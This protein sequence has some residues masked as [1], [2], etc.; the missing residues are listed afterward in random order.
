MSELWTCNRTGP[1]HSASEPTMLNRTR[2]RVG[3][4]DVSSEVTFEPNCSVLNALVNWDVV[5]RF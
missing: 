3:S 5:H 4:R 2:S 1:K